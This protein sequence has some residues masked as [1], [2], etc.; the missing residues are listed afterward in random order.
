VANSLL[1]PTVILKEAGRLFH[2]QAKFINRINRQYDDKFARDGA[3]VGYS[4]ALRDR[5]AYTV[6]TGAT[7]AVQD[8]TEASQTLTVNTQKHVGMNFSSADLTMVIDEFSDRYIKPAVAALV[9]NIESDALISMKKKVANFVDSD[10]NA[11][12]Y[13]D[14]GKAR[15]KLNEN[16]TPPDER[17][18]LLCEEHAVKYADAVK[19]LNLPGVLGKQYESGMIQDVTGF[20]VAGTTHLTPHQTGTAVG[21]DTLYNVNGASQSG[22]S[23]TVDTGSTTFLI[24][25]VITFAG[26][27][28]VHPETKA[29][30]GYLKQFVITANSGANATTLAISP[31]IVLS[32]AKQNVSAAPTTTGAVTKLGSTGSASLTYVESLAFHKDAFIFGTA[33]LEDMS[34]YGG[35]GGREVMDGLSMRIWRQ[36]DIVNDNAPCRID[37]LYGFLAR[38]PQMACRIHADG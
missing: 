28:A 35:W 22:S 9:A 36:G 12:A 13:L 8:T 34:K 38:Y 25:D 7:L 19:G 26:C 6:T 17:T 29:D 20:D 31:A 32:G 27:N 11:F 33:D 5:N 1:S 16:L 37:V 24:G 30:L 18:L 23:I 3:K 2:Q 21:G 4:I 10:T 14:V 15:R